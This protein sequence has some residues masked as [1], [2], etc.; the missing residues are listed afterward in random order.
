VVSSSGSREKELSPLIVSLI[1]P[2]AVA[3]IGAIAVILG[4]I[5]KSHSDMRIANLQV[6]L[7]QTAVQT[8]TAARTEVIVSETPSGTPEP[9]TAATP[10]PTPTPTS[11]PDCGD[12]QV[13]HLV[14]NLSTGTDQA[15]HP[16][17][18][19]VI[20]LSRGDIDGLRTLSGQAVF[21]NPDVTVN[22][23]CT[24]SGRTEGE[25][26]MHALSGTASECSFSI[27]LPGRVTAIYLRLT[28]GEQTRLFTIRVP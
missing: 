4:S 15:K 24:W 22:C 25:V 27:E 3:L 9:T 26:S 1:V 12:V 5:I 23:T 2:I 17:D 8:S 19:G 7:T 13:S 20:N 11:T 16:D 21:A 28:I 10:T 6:E 18:K 14:L